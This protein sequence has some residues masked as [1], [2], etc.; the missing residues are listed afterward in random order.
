MKWW[1]AIKDILMIKRLIHITYFGNQIITVKMIIVRKWRLE[2]ISIIVH[3]MMIVQ[4]RKWCFIYHKLIMIGCILTVER[5]Q[6][7][8]VPYSTLSSPPKRPTLPQI[9][10]GT[11][12]RWFFIFQKFR[13]FSKILQLLYKKCNWRVIWL[14]LHRF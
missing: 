6:T 5:L 2:S 8:I 4:R 14:L 1:E 10:E 3:I 7:T 11:R 12:Q 13:K 9:R